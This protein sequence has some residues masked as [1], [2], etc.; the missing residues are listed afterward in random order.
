MH[1]RAHL[2]NARERAAA[3]PR[4]KLTKPTRAHGKDLE[5]EIE[6]ESIKGAF[7]EFGEVRAL[8]ACRR[9]PYRIGA[10]SMRGYR[11]E[12]EALS[13]R[14][15]RTLAR[16]QSRTRVL[17]RARIESRASSH[18]RDACLSPMVHR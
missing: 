14:C 2:A 17:T 4:S 3:Y 12:D 8:H 16:A 11:R 7:E 1:G 6:A 10:Q 9:S 5:P 18:P 13:R 15:A